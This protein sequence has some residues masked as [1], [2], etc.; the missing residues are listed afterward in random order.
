MV[1]AD[2]ARIAVDTSSTTCVKNADYESMQTGRNSRESVLARD[3]ISRAMSDKA[4]I[5][6]DIVEIVDTCQ[7][8]SEIAFPRIGDSELFAK[9]DYIKSFFTM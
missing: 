6:V 3:I 4:A 1:D 8:E 7:V 5:Q 2:I 9:P